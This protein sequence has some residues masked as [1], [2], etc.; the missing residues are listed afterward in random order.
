MDTPLYPILPGV[1]G[2]GLVAP[3]VSQVQFVPVALGLFTVTGAWQVW[4]T[5]SF[6]AAGRVTIYFRYGLLSQQAKVLSGLLEDGLPEWFMY[7]P[8]PL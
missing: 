6:W 4:I 1:S 3:W 7:A 2:R 5:S 8:L